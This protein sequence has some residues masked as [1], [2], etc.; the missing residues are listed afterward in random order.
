M[1][2]AISQEQL[3]ILV[4]LKIYKELLLQMNSVMTIMKENI[5]KKIFTT[6]NIMFR[7]QML[8]TWYYDTL[9][10][11]TLRITYTEGHKHAKIPSGDK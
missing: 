3:N 4:V 8:C 6:Q 7:T 10:R 5:S 9:L 11:H 2:T 1:Q